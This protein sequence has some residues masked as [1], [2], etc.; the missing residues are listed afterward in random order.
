MPT[1]EPIPEL[2][3][4]TEVAT[5]LRCSVA[6]LMKRVDRGSI[7]AECVVDGV[8]PMLF[9]AVALRTWLGLLRRCDYCDSAVEPDALRGGFCS[10]TCWASAQ[11]AAERGDA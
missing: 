11:A 5:L 3:T 10:R 9:R 2:L 4:A 6:A 7:P 1:P 8:K